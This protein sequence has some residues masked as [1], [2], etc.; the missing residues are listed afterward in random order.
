MALIRCPEC[1]K[2]ISDKA[3]SCPNC[4][5]PVKENSNFDQ[6]DNTYYDGYEN[7]Y[8]S[9]IDK[10]SNEKVKNSKAKKLKLYGITDLIIGI[11]LFLVIIT[12]D[13]NIAGNMRMMG[14][15]WFFLCCGVL[16]MLGLRKKEYSFI[17]IIF[18]LIGILFN[19]L[20]SSMIFAHII[21]VILMIVFL[22]SSVAYL[23]KSGNNYED[24]RLVYENNRNLFLKIIGVGVLS[25]IV[26]ASGGFL[27]EKNA[28]MKN[29]EIVNQ[30]GFEN[31]MSEETQC[32]EAINEYQ[33]QSVRRAESKSTEGLTKESYEDV[34]FYSLMD[35]KE[36]Y[37][38]ESVR[39]VIQVYGC[40]QTENES[41]VRSQNSDYSIVE[42]SA[43][44]KIYP[45]NYQEFESG[46][47]ITVE[48]RLAKDGSEDI[49]AN[50]HIVDF[51]ANS[52]NIFE[53]DLAIYV[54]ERNQI[55]QQE[56]ESFIESCVSVSYDELRRYPDSYM[57][58][59]IKL[60]IYAK[61]VESDGWIFPGDIIA[62]INGEEIAVYDD[63]T[64]REP[65][66]TKGDTVTI[67]AVGYGLSTM[68]VKQK[69]IVFSKTVDE[70]DVPAVKIKYTDKDKD[71]AEALNN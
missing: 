53:S 38:G 40:Y 1:G 69:G 56:K 49:L 64:V 46:E 24:I 9:G 16:H 36:H 41:Y 61:D 27:N 8:L 34:F 5:Y 26:F 18:Y 55:L 20:F 29:E 68:K 15:A 43:D 23:K 44:L 54:A 58:V 11:L 17:C 19:L 60:T 7:K 47:Y 45:D 39:T 13:G 35:N 28:N 25:F 70:Y 42:N 2:E 37:N 66:I 50:A 31:D 14:A 10:P 62:T 32:E 57:D 33:A 71:F 48:G 4:G 22:V 59:P 63:R 3:A 52:K 12:S 21:I 51:G 30:S 6:I 65:R 67:Y